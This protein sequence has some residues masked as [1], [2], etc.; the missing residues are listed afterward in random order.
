MLKMG[1]R[2]KGRSAEKRSPT[3]K[4]DDDIAIICTSGHLVSRAKNTMTR[5]LTRQMMRKLSV[6]WDYAHR[7]KN[8][9]NSP[10]INQKEGA[11]KGNRSTQ[12]MRI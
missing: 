3:R 5:H 6:L 8:M 4:N 12:E 7:A 11:D 10:E 2:K 9:K 1:C